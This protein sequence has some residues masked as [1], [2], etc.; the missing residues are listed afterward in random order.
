MEEFA[1]GALSLGSGDEAEGDG[2]G[3]AFDHAVHDDFFENQVVAGDG[4]KFDEFFE[5]FEGDGGFRVI[6]GV[7]PDEDGLANGIGGLIH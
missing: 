2:G 4:A 1:A 6:D 7:R 5:A 3:F